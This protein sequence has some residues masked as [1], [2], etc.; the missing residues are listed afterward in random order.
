M[1][2]S[3]QTSSSDACQS[4]GSQDGSPVLYPPPSDVTT[5]ICGF[6]AYFETTSPFK[7]PSFGT[8]LVVLFELAVCDTAAS[9]L[10]KRWK[11][12]AGCNASGSR[13]VCLD[14]DLSFARC[15][16]EH[17]YQRRLA[18]LL[19]DVRRRPEVPTIVATNLLVLLEDL[20]KPYFLTRRA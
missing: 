15:R 14:T 12:W 18:G 20:G 8:S 17:E 5:Y 11:H 16:E 4:S 6:A 1:P 19:A 13:A 3:T 9:A 10:R 7:L 2:T